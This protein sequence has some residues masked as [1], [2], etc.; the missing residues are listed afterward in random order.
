[1]EIIYKQIGE[2][3]EQENNPRD[4][5]EAAQKIAESIKEFGFI[6]PIAITADNIII[7]GHTRLKA[8]HLLGLE[9]VP[10]IIHDLPDSDVAFA[11]II[12]NKTT[13]YATWDVSKLQAEMQK[14]SGFAPVFFSVSTSD[15]TAR[16]NN[17]T[18]VFGNNRIPVTETE[19]KNF[20]LVF[21]DYV[22]KNRS[23]L[24]FISHIL[25]D[26]VAAL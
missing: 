10:C 11:G 16:K 5:D 13:E 23:F 14:F 24:G 15:L 1:M 4:N 25:K 3:I 7:S 6:N 21:T 12:D 2:L 20:K 22:E 18:L 19:Y 26:K 17:L 9:E 8:A